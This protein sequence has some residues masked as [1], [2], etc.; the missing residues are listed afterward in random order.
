MAY[1]TVAHYLHSDNFG[2][3]KGKGNISPDQM[4]D[5]VWDYILCRTELT[6]E[7]LTKSKIPKETLEA[8]RREFSY[9][10]PLDIRGSGKDL[11]PNHL[12]FFLYNHV[13]LLDKEWWPRSIRANGH[14]QLNGEKMSKS[15]GN[16]MTLDDGTLSFIL[17][18]GSLL[19]Y[20]SSRE[21]VWR[22]CLQNCPGGCWRLYSRLQLRRGRRRQ[23]YVSRN[24]GD[25][26]KWI[27]ANHNVQ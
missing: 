22:G 7:V 25:P 3:E 18:S 1:Y 27:N 11:I 19:T 23:H 9:F 17:I 20:N 8:M 12:T 6:D 15:T 4:I 16:F 24:T 5:E 21:E 26:I 10:Y 2:R 13:A 14:L